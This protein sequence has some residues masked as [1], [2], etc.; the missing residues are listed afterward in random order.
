MKTSSFYFAWLCFIL[1]LSPFLLQAQHNT[2]ISEDWASTSPSGQM[3]SKTSVKHDGL[4]NVY[5]AGS[6][7]SATN[8]HDIIVKKYDGRGNL[9]WEQTF[10]GDASL[11][12][13][14]V[15]IYVDANDAIYITGATTRDLSYGFSMLVLKYDED[16]V[17]QWATSFDNGVYSPLAG[18]VALVWVENKLHVTGSCFGSGN[19]S[20]IVTLQIDP[21]TGSINWDRQYN[22][23]YPVNFGVFFGNKD[24]N[25]YGIVQVAPA[26]YQRIALHYDA[27]G[28]LQSAPDIMADTVHAVDEVF[29]VFTD[30]SGNIYFACS[31]NSPTSGYDWLVIKMS[32]NYQEQL[33]FGVSSAGMNE[34]KARAVRVDGNGNIYV[35]GYFTVPGEGK[36]IALAKYDSLG[37]Q[38]WIRTYGGEA[39]MDDEAL[40]LEIDGDGR[41][42]VGGYLRNGVYSDYVLM[43]FSSEG[44][45]LFHAEYDSPHGLDDTPTDMSLEHNSITLAGNCR[46][47][48]GKYEPHYVN[49]SLRERIID[50][51]VDTSNVPLYVKNEIIIRFQ[52][53]LVD[54]SFVDSKRRFI[55]LTA[56]VPESVIDMM[57][58]KTGF[59][60]D[61]DNIWAEKIFIDLKTTDTVSTSR[62]GQKVYIDPV[63]SAFVVHITADD[64]TLKVIADSLNY[65]PDIIR[66]AHH[67][68]V[69]L[70][71]DIPNDTH[72]LAGEQKSFFD[73][74]DHPGGI[75]IQSAWDI[76]KG[77]NKVKVGIFDSEMNW[78]H[79]DFGDGTYAGSVVRGWDFCDHMSIQQITSPGYYHGTATGGIIGAIRNNGK[80]VAGIAGKDPA[81]SGSGARI[82]SYKILRNNLQIAVIS[83]V[84]NAI[85]WGASHTPTYGGGL[86]I[87]NHSWGL[88]YQQLYY[89]NGPNQ[90]SFNQERVA[91]LRDAVRTS[92]NNECVFVASRG[93]SNNSLPVYPSSYTDSWVISV[94]ASGDD[95]DYKY[96]GNPQSNNGLPYDYGTSFGEDMDLIAPGVTNIIYSTTTISPTNEQCGNYI[97]DKYNCYAGTS[98]AAPHVSGAAALILSQQNT[99]YEHHT[100]NLTGEDVEHLMQLTADFTKGT[101]SL[102]YDNRSGWGLLRMDNLMPLIKAPEYRVVHFHGDTPD[103][104]SITL[105]NSNITIWIGEQYGSLASGY[106]IADRYTA[107][108]TFGNNLGPATYL[109]GWPLMVRGKGLPDVTQGGAIYNETHYNYSSIGMGNFV[110]SLID[111]SLYFIK[112][113]QG[114]STPINTWIPHDTL[115]TYTP[116]SIWVYDE[117]YYGTSIKEQETD[118]GLNVFPIPASDMVTVDISGAKTTMVNLTLLSIDGKV[119]MQKQLSVNEG[120]AQDILDLSRLSRGIYFVRAGGGGLYQTK[121]IVLQ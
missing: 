105:Q 75:G 116:Y 82:L 47:N 46:K 26:A 55:P 85:H 119:V 3:F 27:S 48:D 9:L 97:P 120:K 67:N 38:Q 52:E 73:N 80:G 74:A 115:K 4:G 118:L 96:A 31:E 90:L 71:L 45:T 59:K 99:A 28:T 18:G 2:I 95:G 50:V 100:A 63:W 32:A 60:F 121:K 42:I 107:S 33:R 25:P 35:A 93:N 102:G 91:L 54:T 70:P 108:L 7:L 103:S 36:N 34:D 101:D 114:S 69:G 10:D 81:V 76:E 1:L 53:T 40:L 77:K 22:N 98:A 62:G 6:F 104:K 21:S 14:A 30:A 113:K 111:L 37:T 39:L 89:N 94:G 19:I 24:V 78:A 84:A 66:Y 20:E 49:Y 11:D 92:A 61:D 13:Y 12:D 23:S 106:Y 15:D 51:A 72:Y 88:R 43:G 110:T 58:D 16:G 83:D 86:H 64:S 79:E 56:L 5:V 112:N 8:G 87:Q 41:I 65:L 44:K 17:Q 29:D 57:A 68:Y 109:N 117:S